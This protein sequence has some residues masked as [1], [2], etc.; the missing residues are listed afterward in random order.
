[1]L[2]VAGVRLRRRPVHPSSSV[3]CRPANRDRP[4]RM[5][6]QLSSI[7]PPGRRLVAAIAPEFTIGFVRPLSPSSRPQYNELNARPCAFTPTLRPLLR[8]EGVAD[9]AK[10]ERLRDAHDRELDVG[11]A[12][13]KDPPVGTSTTQIP[14]RPGGRSGERRVDL[15]D[16]P[17]LDVAVALGAPRRR[18]RR[19]RPRRAG[20]RSRRTGA[21][22]RRA[23]SCSSS[24][25]PGRGISRTGAGAGMDRRPPRRGGLRRGAAS[26]GAARS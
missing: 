21:P 2:L 3:E 16:R 15:R 6:P 24:S 5:T 17:G 14:K 11:V 10:D 4:S 13:S 19:R 9:E 1:M 25:P 22:P 18:G 26:S 20:S 23:C 12:Y 8:P 7:V